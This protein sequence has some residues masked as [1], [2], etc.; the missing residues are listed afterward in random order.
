MR[1]WDE[2]DWAATAL[3]ASGRHTGCRSLAWK[4]ARDLHVRAMFG[5]LERGLR[6]VLSDEVPLDTAAIEAFED[7]K[8]DSV[9]SGKCFV[10]G[11]VLDRG[12]EVRALALAV[13]GI[14]VA[15][16]TL[17]QATLIAGNLLPSTANNRQLT[18]FLNV[19]GEENALAGGTA[20]SP[21]RKLLEGNGSESTLSDEARAA[22]EEAKGSPSPRRKAKQQASKAKSDEAKIKAATLLTIV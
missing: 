5:E 3:L 12:Q 22:R 7:M 14:V 17:D 18:S 4:P 9:S 21:G 19:S 2:W 20:S 13:D 6:Q 1:D 8:L 15:A 10:L 16:P 11:A